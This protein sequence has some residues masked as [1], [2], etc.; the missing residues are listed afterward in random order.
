MASPTVAVPMPNAELV[1]HIVEELV[2]VMCG[3]TLLDPRILE[4]QHVFCLRCLFS[5][6]VH[7]RGSHLTIKCAYRC[8]EV[9]TTMGDIRTLQKNPIITSVSLL[10]RTRRNARLEAEHAELAAT[11]AAAAAASGDTAAVSASTDHEVFE[12]EWCSLNSASCGVCQYCQSRLCA[13]CRGH[14]GDHQFLCVSVHE[15]GA[16]QIAAMGYAGEPPSSPLD[17]AGAAR[18]SAAGGGAGNEDGDGGSFPFFFSEDDLL[19]LILDKINEIIAPHALKT[20]RDPAAPRPEPVGGQA[21]ALE[22]DDV[23]LTE[24]LPVRITCPL[25]SV[26]CSQT[27]TG[28]TAVL[29]VQLPVRVNGLELSLADVHWGNEDLGAET[30]L[31]MT[32]MLRLANRLTACVQGTCAESTHLLDE[33]SSIARRGLIEKNRGFQLF[34][35]HVAT[36]ARM[37]VT[38]ARNCILANLVRARMTEGLMGDM[39]ANRYTQLYTQCPVPDRQPVRRRCVSFLKAEML[40]SERLDTAMAAM[41]EAC[42]AVEDVVTH[43]FLRLRAMAT[44]GDCAAAVAMGGGGSSPAGG[45]PKSGP[46]SAGRF[47]NRG[48]FAVGRDPLRVPPQLFR[49]PSNSL[50]AGK[51]AAT[52]P[53]F[54]SFADFTFLGQQEERREAMQ[55]VTRNFLATLEDFLKTRHWVWSYS[56]MTLRSCGLSEADRGELLRGEESIQLMT[57]GLFKELWKYSRLLHTWESF[58]VACDDTQVP[59]PVDTLSELFLT[60]VMKLKMFDSDNDEGDQEEAAPAGD[61]AAASAV[62]AVQGRHR[63]DAAPTATADYFM[64]RYSLAEVREGL[65]HL[66]MLRGYLLRME[67]ADIVGPAR[68]F[69]TQS[70][71]LNLMKGLIQS[72]QQHQLAVLQAARAAEQAAVITV[73]QGVRAIGARQ[74]KND[75]P[76]KRGARAVE[77]IR[78]LVSLTD[79]ALVKHFQAIS[80]CPFL[81]RERETRKRLHLVDFTRRDV[82]LSSSCSFGEVLVDAAHGVTLPEA[83]AEQQLMSPHALPEGAAQRCPLGHDAVAA[84]AVEPSESD[85][86]LDSIVATLGADIIAATADVGA[87]LESPSLFPLTQAPLPRPPSRAGSDDVEGGAFRLP[88]DQSGGSS[89]DQHSLDNSSGSS[90]AVTSLSAPDHPVTSY[91]SPAR[92]N[93]ATA[94]G[95]GG[96]HSDGDEDQRANAEAEAR[97]GCVPLRHLLEMSRPFLE[98]IFAA[99]DVP[100]TLRQVFAP[101][102]SEGNGQDFGRASSV[103]VNHFRISCDNTVPLSSRDLLLPFYVGTYRVRG[104]DRSMFVV[105]AQT[106]EVWMEGVALPSPLSALPLSPMAVIGQ[107]AVFCV[108]NV[109]IRRFFGSTVSCSLSTGG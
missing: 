25:Q 30:L 96:Q 87:P 17:S 105:D 50:A 62:R 81:E 72:T 27:P 102:R 4:C 22:S 29:H 103:F 10:L 93:I 66:R 70:E 80:G 37:Q 1:E 32:N 33:L 42:G 94:L 58:V 100:T 77:T 5:Q 83:R 39:V 6:A 13:E 59:W 65:E 68:G 19:P 52:D 45:A 101:P 79:D 21:A 38:V 89:A 44:L 3:T 14:F 64:V 78:T 76:P 84:E 98:R 46:G 54:E 28:F 34:A 48:G 75:P 67:S 2:C 92:R 35:L 12:C 88:M 24:I 106:G 86:E 20:A 49:S 71:L 18:T 61:E 8:R 41:H 69:D 74:M 63:N 60:P 91:V 47:R 85:E 95:T 55:A 99:D 51:R 23:V 107:L 31:F 26:E 7:D 97:A 40:L 56:N 53:I 108:V 11:A 57:D 43:I 82:A 104:G 36:V 73:A 16:V 90:S 15:R 9:T 109:I